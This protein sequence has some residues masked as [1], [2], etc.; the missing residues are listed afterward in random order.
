MDTV[1][2][3]KAFSE[4]ADGSFGRIIAYREA[5]SISRVSIPTRTPKVEQALWVD[6][7]S[8]TLGNGTILGTQYWSLLLADGALSTGYSQVSLGEWKLV[9]L[10]HN[11]HP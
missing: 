5:R 7:G 2:L 11:L 3:D 8:P 1:M 4:S 9:L 10:S 6:N